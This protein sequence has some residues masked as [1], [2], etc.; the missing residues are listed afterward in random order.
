[1]WPQDETSHTYM[2][3]LYSSIYSTTG[4]SGKWQLN[5]G[6]ETAKF[7]NYWTSF[8][9]CMVLYMKLQESG[10]VDSSSL[11]SP[12]TLL[13]HHDN[14]ELIEPLIGHCWVWHHGLYSIGLAF[15]WVVIHCSSHVTSIA[16][17]ASAH[18]P[19][20]KA[21]Q[22]VPSCPRFGHPA[23]SWT[24]DLPATRPLSPSFHAYTL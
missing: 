12:V 6:E 3:I 8:Q 5:Y 11:Q 17:I 22:E 1:M 19:H 4:R 20:R 14:S 15:Y 7:F 10:L 23:A 2:Y 9:Y 21:G 13:V 18:M 16:T 24:I